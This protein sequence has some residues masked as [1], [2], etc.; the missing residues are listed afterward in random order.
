MSVA[1]EDLPT[2]KRRLKLTAIDIR[3]AKEASTADLKS[4]L[5]KRRIRSGTSDR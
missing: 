1:D 4:L 5:H 3:L 2:Q